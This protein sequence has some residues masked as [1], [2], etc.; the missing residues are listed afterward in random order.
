LRIVKC[1]C[2]FVGVNFR[3]FAKTEMVVNNLIHGFDTT[4]K[5]LLLLFIPFSLCTKFHD[6]IDPTKTMKIRIL[7]NS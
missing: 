3:G 1:K 7:I 2:I 6:L 5:W 4:W